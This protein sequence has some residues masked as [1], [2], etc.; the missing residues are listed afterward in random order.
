MKLQKAKRIFFNWLKVQGAYDA[1]KQARH[2]TNNLI[3]EDYRT[4]PYYRCHLFPHQFLNNAFTWRLTPEGHDFWDNINS[5][6]RKY[7]KE[8]ETDPRYQ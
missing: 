5:K 4:T 2:N 3:G 7:L 6:W 1:Y 8:I